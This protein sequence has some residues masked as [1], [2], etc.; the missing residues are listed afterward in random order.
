MDYSKAISYWDE[1]D[2]QTARMER[3]ALLPEIEAFIAAHKTCAL[4]TGFG[5]FV[6]CTPIEYTYY[7]RKFWLLSEGGLKFRALRDNKNVCLAIYDPYIGF[8]KLG[9]MQVTGKAKLVEP[10]S[11]QYLSLLSYKKISAENL[12][13]LPHSLYLI[14]ITP[15]RIDFLWSGFKALG[16]DVRQ[17]LS[18]D[19]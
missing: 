5:E 15:T 11:E 1:K 4:A 16:Y 7:D 12:K 17:H 6:R 10:W 13:K 8:D 2:R 9:G 14:C 18:F 19:A 3:D